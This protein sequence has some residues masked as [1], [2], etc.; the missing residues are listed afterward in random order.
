MF[1]DDKSIL[2]PYVVF[3]TFFQNPTKAYYYGISLYKSLG[4]HLLVVKCENSFCKYCLKTN[5]SIEIK[6]YVAF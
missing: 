6:F 4:C 1:T 5:N 3:W 2:A